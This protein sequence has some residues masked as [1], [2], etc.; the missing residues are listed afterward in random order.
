VQ[1]KSTRKKKRTEFFF[2]DSP[3]SA[4]KISV[5]KKSTRKQNVLNFF[6]TIRRILRKKF[7]AKKN[8]FRKNE[9]RPLHSAESAESAKI[10][11]PG[12]LTIF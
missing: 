11:I 12:N 5:Q 10:S 8:G 6:L 4:E 1:K 9:N 7:C 2:N 3:N